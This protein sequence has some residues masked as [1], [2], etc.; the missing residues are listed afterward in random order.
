[1]NSPALL[2]WEISEN[3]FLSMSLSMLW[4]GLAPT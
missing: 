1:L 2:L 4:F 3:F